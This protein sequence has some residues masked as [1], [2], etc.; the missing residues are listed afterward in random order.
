MRSAELSRPNT[1]T[2]TSPALS[3]KRPRAPLGSSVAEERS[4]LGEPDPGE[5]R[6]PLGEPDPGEERSPLGEPDRAGDRRPDEALPE[7]D[8]PAQGDP[9]PPD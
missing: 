5:E 6:P 8:R 4:P 1:R 3:S 7:T 9:M 2:R